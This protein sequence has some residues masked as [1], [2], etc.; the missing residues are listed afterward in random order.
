MLITEEY[1]EAQK[2]LHRD[3]NYG[4]ASEKFADIVAKAVNLY[5]VQELLDYGAGKMRLLKAISDRR[6]VNHKFR[7]IPYEPADERYAERPRPCEMV[8]CIDVLEHYRA[9]MLGRCS[10]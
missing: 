7:Y 4:T 3:P 6:L 1:R 5:N 8:T 2:H 10:R 9:G